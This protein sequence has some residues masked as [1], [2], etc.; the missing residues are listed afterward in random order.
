MPRS[1]KGSKRLAAAL[2]ALAVLG[3]GSAAAR[4]AEIR[5]SSIVVRI[6]AA[7]VRPDLRNLVPIADGE[8]YLPARIDAAVKQIYATGLF[9]DVE[10]LAEGETDVRLTFI[11]K[12][13]LF[14]RKV[15]F[16]GDAPVSRKMLLAGLYA[17][18]PDTE[19]SAPRL[20]RAEEEL[21][22]V[23]RREGFLNARVT[24]RVNP[25]PEEPFV[26]LDFE[27]QA[28]LRFTVRSVEFRG[29]LDGIQDAAVKAMETRSGRPYRPTILEADMAAVKA[30]Y[31]AAGYPRAEV[32][33]QN[34]SFRA[35]DSTIGLVLRVEPGERIRITIEGA[36]V[37]ESLVRPLWEERIFEIWGLEQAEAAILTHLRK[38]GNVF[39]SVR[40]NVER[41]PG[42]LHI[43]HQVAPGRKV[44]IED[45]IFD[46]AAAFP[47]GEIRRE[48]GLPPALPIFGSISGD[49]LFTVP[50]EVETFYQS[51]G[52]PET[53]VSLQFREGEKGTLAVFIVEEGPRQTVRNVSFLGTKIFTEDELF[54]EVETRSG[55][56][57]EPNRIRRDAERLEAAYA[58]RGVR[59]TMVAARAEDLGDGRFDVFFDLREGRPV[60]IDKIVVSGNAVTRR[61]VIDRA[62]LVK[63]GD[64][65]RTGLIRES[66]HRLERLGVFVE[67]KIEELLSEGG[68]AETLVVS[69]REGQ[70][71]YASFGIGVET[72]N[73]PFELE[74]WKNILSPRFTAEYIRGNMLGRANQL[75]LVGQFSLLEKRAVASWESPTFFGLPYQSALNGWIEREERPSY[76]F[77]R[78]GVS[79]SASRAI[80]P[81]WTSLT[82]ARVA[83]TTLYFL[84][85]AESEV[86]RQHFPY[87]ATAL[88]ETLIWD[89]RDDSF[90]PA[91][92]HFFSAVI[93]W[94]YPLF[95]AESDYLKSFIKFQY[96]RPL[97][98][99][100]LLIGTFRGGLGMGRMPIH[101]RF[102]AGGSG[103]FRGRP[104]DGLGP[105]DAASGKPVG[106]KAILLFNLDAQFR[107]FVSLPNLSLA[108]FYD[109]GNVFSHRSDVSLADLENALGF[110]L[111]YKTPLG[112]L[113][114]DLGW[115]LNSP[116]GSRRGPRLY[117]TIGN[118]F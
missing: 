28:G 115:N 21:R 100:I 116:D 84:K 112:P 110:G 22:D 35:A 99:Q 76:G 108:V 92:G 41:S 12:R 66:K 113:R 46:G 4:E 45:V 2:L 15:A 27:I 17:L 111:R 37:P 78:R 49:R 91:R 97:G 89:A 72:K 38:K 18:R 6:E 32:V 36:D 109:L 52:F 69:L 86:D 83:Q 9:A 20:I 98:E 29:G 55:G 62:L 95:K 88:S 19:Y 65:A 5:I 118:V 103:S 8:L 93:D 42:E 63:E 34:R 26:D 79:L 60:R 43:I 107:P 53:R 74:I 25:D 24:G 30:A 31:G 50:E 101:E 51:R 40:S 56:A 3:A 94:A 1:E 73:E 67:V 61:D 102:F 90:N 39:A 16:S 59:G 57:Y 23:V 77:D 13:K 48:I 114:V 81:G 80:G 11:L 68:E 71:N 44:R 64:P 85:I 87:S 7:E 75:S 106:G 70:R 10:V 96:F 117:V 47:A 14:T 82:T 104:F 33:V 58:D 54:G 105:K